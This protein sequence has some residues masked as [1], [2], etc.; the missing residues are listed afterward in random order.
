[1]ETT[2]N[3][4]LITEYLDQTKVL[5]ILEE[6]A[7]EKSLYITGPMLQ[8]NVK[9]RNGRWYPDEIMEGQ[10]KRYITEKIDTKRA[11]GELNHPQRPNVDPREASHLVTELYRDGDNWMGKAKV[12]SRTPVGGIVAGLIREGVSLGVSSRGVGS[13][14]ENARGILEVQ[15]DYFLSAIDVVSD[16]S[17]PD[18]FVNGIM[19]GAE[20]VWGNNGLKQVD[21]SN[22][23]REVE[24]AVVARAL[25]EARLLSV[26]DRLLK[27][28]SK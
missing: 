10:V 5:E 4:R 25:D 3:L 9:N 7:Q 19:E 8:A 22:A 13:L 17:G 12:L 1:M 15:S 23:R 16:P 26:F 11:L 24:Q 21:L 20:W 2:N 28:V 6:G 27:T 18:C 14:K